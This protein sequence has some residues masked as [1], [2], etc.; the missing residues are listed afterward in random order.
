MTRL[1]RFGWIADL[2]NTPIDADVAGMS[3]ALPA[4]ISRPF[5][6]VAT[7]ALS[8]TVWHSVIV[9]GAATAMLPVDANPPHPT[10]TKGANS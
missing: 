7:T 1:L 6:Q 10:P 3:D 8:R 2:G 5:L 4:V 9:R